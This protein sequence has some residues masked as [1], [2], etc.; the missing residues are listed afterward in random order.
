M[1]VSK[2][3]QKELK[4][5]LPITCYFLL[6]FNLVVFTK[7]LFLKQFAIDY[8]GF[9]LASLGAILMA[10][11]ILIA[12]NLKVMNIFQKRPRI[13]N[14]IWQTVIYYILVL[15]LQ[16][17]EH[18]LPPWIKSGDFLATNRDF[19]AALVWP[20]FWAVQIW[21]VIFIFIYVAWSQIRQIVGGNKIYQIFFQ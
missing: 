14:T 17:I 1:K 6:A 4:H 5:L 15:F 7:M 21:L 9:S 8:V 16:Y 19:Y 3:I 11:I 2:I 18:I 13:Y 10:K 12:E 20:Q